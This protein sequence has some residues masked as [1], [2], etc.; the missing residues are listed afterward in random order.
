MRILALIYILL[1][2][3]ATEATEV[4]PGE[5]L[6]KLKPDV[7][8]VNTSAWTKLLQRKTHWGRVKSLI[9]EMGIIVVK[10][11]EFEP[12]GKAIAY[13]SK[14]RD[15]EKTEPNY[16]YE[17]FKVPNDP[18][19]KELWGLNNFGQEDS[20][21]RN[22]RKGFDIQAE[23][24]W[25]I[26]TGSK[27]IIVAVIDSGVD[28]KNENLRD[29]IWTNEKE[30]NGTIGI[31]DDSNGFIDDIYGYNFFNDTSNPMD[32]YGHGTHCAGTIGAKGNDGVG[33][34]GVAWDVRIMSIKFLGDNGQGTLEN[35]IRSIL[36]ATKMGANIMNN[37]WGGD[38]FSDLMKEAIEEANRKNV[39]FVAAA[40][41]YAQ[42]S[43][44]NPVYPANYDVEN[45]IAVAALENNG[46]LASFSN[47]GGKT[48]H[49]AAPGYNILSTILR[50]ELDSWSGTSMA[51]PH[52]SG[53]AALL[54]SKFPSLK[55]VEV[56][57][58][59]IKTSVPARG[60]KGHIVSGGIVSALKAL[61]EK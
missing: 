52:V 17:A 49:V 6:I 36:Y 26:E 15:I 29:N 32:D 50:G 18:M 42:L 4:V 20:D 41:N 14:D 48:V 21:G 47:Y 22:G 31:D 12:T 37:S 59:L 55:P 8:P 9:P 46:A 44:L 30:R 28:Y 16:I 11:S 60:L 2:A 7:K 10:R 58:R 39:I 1:I 35:G 61:T 53:I 3:I 27:R 38:P 33:I 43:D 51:A 13:F 45:V 25:D 19:Y 40:G 54:L 57:N 56:K 34:T 24:A 23:K 5:F